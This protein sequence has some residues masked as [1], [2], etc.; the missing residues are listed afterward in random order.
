[1]GTAAKSTHR[2]PWNKGKIVARCA[3][4]PDEQKAYAVWASAAIAMA[5]LSVL[6]L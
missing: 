3:D 5:R 1:M 6:I 4:R 2:E